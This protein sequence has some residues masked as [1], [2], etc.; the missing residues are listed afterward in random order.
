MYPIT[1][2]SYQLRIQLRFASL[3]IYPRRDFTGITEVE[4]GNAHDVRE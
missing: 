3:I 2:Q 1:E 4:P